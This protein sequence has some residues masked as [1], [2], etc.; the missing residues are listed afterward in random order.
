LREEKDGQNDR[1]AEDQQCNAESASLLAALLSPD[2][3]KDTYSQKDKSESDQP[4]AHGLEEDTQS[5]RT[6]RSRDPERK[7]ARQRPECT[8]HGSNGSEPF[9]NSH[10]GSPRKRPST[11]ATTALQLY[12][13]TFQRAVGAENTTISGFGPQHNVALNTLME[14]ATGVEGHFLQSRV[15]TLR[16][17][18]R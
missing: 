12:R 17:R 6:H 2:H 5:Q 18:Q 15:T 11:I 14:E 3:L 9:A 13:R 4:W 10:L 1:R 7:A 8:R 16:A